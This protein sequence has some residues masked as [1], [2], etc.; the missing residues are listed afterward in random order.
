MCQRQVLCALANCTESHGLLRT[1]SCCWN[2]GHMWSWKVWP[3]RGENTHRGP[4][5]PAL[6]TRVI[7]GSHLV[8][9]LP[10]RWVKET[11]PYL[12]ELEVGSLIWHLQRFE[13]VSFHLGVGKRLIESMSGWDHGSLT[14]L[15]CRGGIP[16]DSSLPPAR[17]RGLSGKGWQQ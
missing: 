14:W 10:L 7:L 2:C 4:L 5:W 12:G 6:L 8:T 16:L 11:F 9:H 13:R 17:S 3:G 15:G 1:G